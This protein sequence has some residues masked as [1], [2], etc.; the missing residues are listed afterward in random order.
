MTDREEDNG[1]MMPQIEV[2]QTRVGHVCGPQ[3][4]KRPRTESPRA[5]GEAQ[6]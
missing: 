2:L 4:C 6:P 1:R 3:S 5:I